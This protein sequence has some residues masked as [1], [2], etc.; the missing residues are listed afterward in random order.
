[1][2]KEEIKGKCMI[3]KYCRASKN[4]TN[5]EGLVEEYLAQGLEM[6]HFILY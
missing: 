2:L 5:F 3:L 6:I 1:M 4:Q